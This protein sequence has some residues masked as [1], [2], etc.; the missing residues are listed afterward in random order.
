MPGSIFCSPG[1]GGMREKLA[2]I[3]GVR[4]VFRAT[5]VRYGAKTGW[6]GRIERTILFRDVTDSD[7]NLLCDHVWV[8]N[9]K[10]FDIFLFSE[11]CIVEFTARITPYFRKKF[12]SFDFRLSHPTKI[13]LLSRGENST[14]PDYQFDECYEFLDRDWATI[15][16]GAIIDDL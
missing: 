1:V 14:Y 7:G 13:R 16:A 6:K 9:T 10:G 4:K 8:N 2:D 5:F 11:G 12:Y 15:E 3:E